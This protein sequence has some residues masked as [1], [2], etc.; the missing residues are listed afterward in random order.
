MSGIFEATERSLM[1]LCEA[2]KSVFDVASA[3]PAD[4][5]K[6]DASSLEVANG[7]GNDWLDKL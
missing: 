4:V 6:L 1:R 7:L 3:T 5:G 2:L